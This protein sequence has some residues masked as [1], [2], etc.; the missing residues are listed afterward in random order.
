LR[1]GA[2]VRGAPRYRKEER[3]ATDE[4][5]E[6]TIGGQIYAGRLDNLSLVGCQVRSAE[7]PP[8]D[9]GQEIILRVPGVGTAPTQV[10]GFRAKSCQ[11]SFSPDATQ[12]AALVRKLLSGQYRKSVST[13]NP[14]AFCAILWR[15][16]FS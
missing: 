13:M 7:L 4:P 11:L 15:R 5:A 14:L 3:F 12:R 16:A 2:D 10:R 9:F 1:R 8:M 6:A